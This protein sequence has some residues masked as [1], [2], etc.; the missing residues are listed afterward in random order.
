VIP[1]KFFKLD[2]VRMM[3]D[4]DVISVE[5]VPEV[6]S[7]LYECCPDVGK[8]FGENQSVEKVKEYIEFF[9]KDRYIAVKG[10]VQSGKTAFMI[11]ASMITLLCGLDAVII[12]RNSNSDLNQI[13]S[14]LKTFQEEIRLRFQKSFEMTTSKKPKSSPL[15]QLVLALANGISLNKI[16]SILQKDYIL[17]VDEADH[18]DSGTNTRKATVLPMLK[19]QAHCT[20]GVSA[21]VMDLLG[22]ESIVPKDLVLLTPP[23]SYKGIPQILD[24]ITEYIPPGAVYS[25]KVDSELSKNDPY[26]MEWIG[27]LIEEKEQPVIALVTICDT[28]DPC[29]KMIEKI[30]DRYGEELTVID[31]HADRIMIHSNMI[32]DEIKGGMIS[33]VLQSLKD[34]K[35]SHPIIIFAGDLSG[36]GLSYVSSDYKWHLTHQRLIV[37]NT[38]PEPELIQ[39]V[40]LC[41][42]YS[43]DRPLRLVT[44]HEIATDLRKAY[45]KQEELV[46]KVREASDK[47]SGECREFFK[48]VIFEKEKMTKRMITKDP[49]ARPELQLVDF[50]T[51]WKY[52]DGD[53][54]ELETSYP[55]KEYE[56]LV[57]KMFP[58]WAKEEGATNISRFMNSLDP[59][60][61][62]TPREMKDLCVETGVL[63]KNLKN[64]T[65]VSSRL[66]NGYGMILEIV[67][68]CYRLYPC[69]REAFER[70]FNEK[71][72][73]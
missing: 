71:V 49:K 6:F 64:L 13:Y 14:R 57:N 2:L 20:F 66:S 34:K 24:Q 38:C 67:N 33:E 23:A 68:D 12:L 3:E 52:Y 45:Y 5:S 36:R 42:V 29:I 47:F 54:A 48:E 73:R 1:E 56:R 18:I 43:D 15:P 53:E 44:T 32:E 69:L 40:R 51:G 46:D 60:K 70:S 62:Y 35:V 61:E 9:L 63:H 37:S 19:A 39:K 21:T 50:P 65:I 26:L 4:T 22:K 41:G 72:S 17:I 28:V 55:K 16:F 8:L 7:Y 30:V 31:H 25:S 10:Q 27:S 11:C 58:K 59:E